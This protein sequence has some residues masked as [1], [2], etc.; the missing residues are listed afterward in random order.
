MNSMEIREKFLNYF[1]KNG[2]EIVSSSSLIPA[3]DPTLLFTNAGMNQFKDLFL[4]NE[5]RLYKTACSIQKCVRAGGKHN[6]LEEVGFTNR[7]LTFFEMMGNFSFGD[8]FKKDA[9]KYAWEFLTKE[10]NINPKDLKITIYKDDDQAYEIWNKI[11]G[12]PAD[13]IYRLGEKENFWQMGDTG[14]CGPCTEIHFDN[15]KD[16]GCKSDHCDPSCSCGRFTEIWNLVFMQFERQQDGRLIPLQQT[17]IDTGM[18]FERLNMILQKKD[19]VFQT[20]IFAPIIKKIENLTKLSYDKSDKNTKAAFHVLCDHVRSSS[21]L[22]ADG[23]LPSNEGRGYVLRKIIRRAALFAQKLSDNPKLFSSLSKEFIS[24]FSLIYK[25]LKDNEKLILATLDDEIAKFSEN[26]K[27]GKVI[28]EKYIEENKKNN[29]NYLSGEQVF[30]L[31][32]TYGFPS[33]L[34]KVIANEQDFTLDMSGFNEEMKKQQEQSGKKSKDKIIVL[35]IPEDINTKFL[36]YEKLELESEI[37]FILK[38]KDFSWIITKESPF[39]VE[40][41]GQIS[42]KGWLNIDNKIYE[43][44]EFYKSVNTQNPAIAVKIKNANLKLGDKVKCIV[45]YYSRSN[46]AKNHTATHLLQAALVQILGKHIQQA[47][48]LVNSDFFRFDYTSNNAISKQDAE[49]IENIVNQKIQENIKLNI[50]YTTLQEAKKAGVTALFGEKYNPEQVRVVQVPGFSAELCGGTHVNSTGDIGLFKIESDVALSSGVRRITGITG[51]K[52]IETFQS[53]FDTIKTLVEKFKVKPEQILTAIEKQ[54][55]NMDNLNSQIKQLKKQILKA[56]IPE[57]QNQV[58]HVGKI[59]FLFLNLQD[60]DSAQFKEICESIETKAQGFYFIVNTNFKTP[61]Q[62][63]F[64]GY[65]SKNF[66]KQIDLKLFSKDILAKFGLKGGGS[67]TLIQGGG[68]QPENNIEQE[69][70]MWLKAI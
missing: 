14:P 59:P 19:S 32:D 33:E 35:D 25:E 60:F 24:Y 17:G 1:K 56:Q 41:G 34:T 70:I 29:K 9:I 42:D 2:H 62:I 61:D 12:I 64:F 21:L 23:C 68:K 58:K 63:S 40:S 28:L 4:G 36:G 53:S 48:S 52:A 54:T 27:S 20:E 67:N 45:D 5:K 3:Q 7:H 18:G 6:D 31:Y 37:N 47:G 10:V 13:K 16:V 46:T 66:E 49:K 43:I 65:V 50:F 57:W 15:G 11:I 44:E 39:Y 26:L 69:I 8:Y 38:E 22:I 51:P 55:E 30:K